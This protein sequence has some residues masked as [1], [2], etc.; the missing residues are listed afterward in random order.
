[1]GDLAMF[2]HENESGTL[3][4]DAILIQLRELTNLRLKSHR[5]Q[6]ELLSMLGQKYTLLS[7]GAKP[8]NLRYIEEQII[9][10]TSSC[11]VLEYQIQTSV[12][13]LNDMLQSGA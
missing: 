9:V 8:E 12:A 4:Y 13:R 10:L 6:I 11:E 5:S 1:M 7:K 2:P 3:S